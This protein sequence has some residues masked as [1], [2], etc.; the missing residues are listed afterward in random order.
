MKTVVV[1]P[2]R[3]SSRRLPGKPLLAILKK[4]L[5]RWIYESAM[6]LKEADRVLVATDDT[7]IEKEV[8]NFGG[9]VFRTSQ[10]ART[11]SD[12]VAEI[13]DKIDG[14]AFLNWQ[15][16]ELFINPAPIDELIISFT[17]DQP[18]DMGTIKREISDPSDLINPNVVKVVTDPKGFA[19]YFS[20]SPIP[21]HRSDDT[22]SE[23]ES[24]N[25]KLIPKTYYKHMG[26]YIYTRR[27]L[28]T[29]SSFSSGDL[30]E[31]EKLEQL[32][33]LE[34]GLRIKVWETSYPSFRID[35][36]EDLRE[37][38]SHLMKSGTL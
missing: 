33:A 29:F 37:A 32:R 5:I 22:K 11:G 3:W 8:K 36:S 7:R 20:R 30:E 24:P 18:L 10:K 4:P 34:F 31:C 13:M 16:D 6:G 17:K 28:K 23:L 19:L 2:C 27:G 1:I 21:F 35:T 15:G 25:L 26:I 38:E 12:R 14:D 9:E